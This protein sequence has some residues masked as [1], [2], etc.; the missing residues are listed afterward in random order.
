MNAELGSNCFVEIH[1]MN[2]RGVV[3]SLRSTGNFSTRV[4]CP[5]VACKTLSPV[6]TAT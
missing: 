6:G 5:G 2:L 4:A 1:R 3:V